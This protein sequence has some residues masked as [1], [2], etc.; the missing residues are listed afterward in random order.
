MR[1]LF[2]INTYVYVYN[3]FKIYNREYTYVNSHSKL[4]DNKTCISMINSW[5]DASQ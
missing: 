3:K 1:V 4:D 2:L 5:I